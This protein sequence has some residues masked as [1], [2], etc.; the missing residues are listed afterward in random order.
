[1]VK[2]WQVIRSEPLLDCRVFKVRKDVTVNPRTGQAHEMFVLEN[3]NWV[4]IIPL[5]PDDQVVMI[6][7]WR[8]GTRSVH[9]ETPGGLM[10]EGESPEDCGRRELLE[11]TGYAAGEVVRLGTVHPNPA[12]QDNLQHFILATNCRRV[13][14]LQLDHAEDI[15]V[16]L[17]P[18]VE[19]PALIQSGQLT[20]GIVIGGFYWLN[21]YRQQHPQG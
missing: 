11:E 17:V 5:T 19:V 3:S 2:P 14:E 1:M 15:S 4:N 12:V 21:L 7:Q 20:H 10:E 6:R 13:G 16:Q 18:L 8:H 9:L